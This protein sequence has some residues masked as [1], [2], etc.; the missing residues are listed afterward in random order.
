MTGAIAP[1]IRSLR[2]RR[3]AVSP[4]SVPATTTTTTTSK[5]GDHGMATL[6]LAVVA[7]GLL[8]LLSLLAA[9][10][11]ISQAQGA[12]NQAAADAARQAS[13]ARSASQA[14]SSAR[15][16]A[17]ATL[18]GQ[19]LRCDGLQV[20]ID[21]GAFSTAVGT[22]ANVSATV[23]CPVALGDIAL[24]GLPGTKTVTSTWVSPLD[25]IRER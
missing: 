13:L 19:G 22:D 17:L 8:M 25:T 18:S 3:R 24:P 6:E 23:S 5:A 11:R 14:T 20:S 16:G 4:Q 15:S 9:A 10:G 21:T 1:T 12:V 7:V 2:R